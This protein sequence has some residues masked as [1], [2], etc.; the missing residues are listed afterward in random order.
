MTM[1]YPIRAGQCRSVESRSSERDG[2]HRSQPHRLPHGQVQVQ[3]RHPPRTLARHAVHRIRAGLCGAVPDCSRRMGRSPQHR[4]RSSRRPLRRRTCR[5]RR[6]RLWHHLSERLGVAQ[7]T[8]AP[9]QCPRCPWS[10]CCVHA[11]MVCR[12][13]VYTAATM[14]VAQTG[15]YISS[16]LQ[17]ANTAGP[18]I[19][20]CCAWT[21]RS[22]A[23]LTSSSMHT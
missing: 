23:H 12:R 21:A 4:L 17:H 5:S 7:S 6:L 20:V 16:L 13:N 22:A 3:R 14:M 2:A 8:M 1:R 11:C 15:V 19:M 9:C 18:A 10:C